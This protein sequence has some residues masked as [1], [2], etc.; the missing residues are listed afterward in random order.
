MIDIKFAEYHDFRL[1]HNVCFTH[2]MY[3][4]KYLECIVILI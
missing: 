2:S 1:Y 4:V 3:G